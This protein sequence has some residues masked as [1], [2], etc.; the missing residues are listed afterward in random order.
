MV[1]SEI[2]DASPQALQAVRWL[3]V[4][5]K[6]EARRGEALDAVAAWLSDPSYAS[7]ATALLVAG[8]VFALEENFVEALKA[9]HSSSN[10]EM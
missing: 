8:L 4:Y 1:M 10:L 2:T 9:C 7:N 3:A 5:M 6:D